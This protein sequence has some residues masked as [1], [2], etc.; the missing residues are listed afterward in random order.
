M[1]C[2]NAAGFHGHGIGTVDVALL[3]AEAA[4]LAAIRHAQLPGHLISTFHSRSHTSAGA[5]MQEHRTSE[6]FLQ[7]AG[8]IGL[9]RVAHR[10]TVSSQALS[11]DWMHKYWTGEACPGDEP[12]WECIAEGRGLIY[13]TTIRI[14]AYEK[15]AAAAPES[16]GQLELGRIALEMGSNL[17]HSAPFIFSTGNGGFRIDYYLDINDQN[18]GLM[19]TAGHFI[20]EIAD[21]DGSHINWDVLNL[22]RGDTKLPDLRALGF[23]FNCQDFHIDEQTL[24]DSVVSR[25]DGSTWLGVVTEP[26][27]AN[28]VPKHHHTP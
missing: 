17:Y 11:A 23:T 14:Q 3:N 10:S 4:L 1:G 19:V 21:K 24:I 28:L 7:L 20:K 5:A 22:L 13:G 9:Q 6:H 27:G 15:V 2:D 26:P 16:L 18:S 8:R 12:L 25:H